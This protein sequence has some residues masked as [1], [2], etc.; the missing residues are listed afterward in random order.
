MQALVHQLSQRIN[1]YIRKL[2]YDIILHHI[3]QVIYF[4]LQLLNFASSRKRSREPNCTVQSIDS[5]KPIRCKYFLDKTRLP[6]GNWC[7][8]FLRC[9]Q[10]FFVFIEHW[11]H[12]WH[13]CWWC[14]ASTFRYWSYRLVL[15]EEKLPTTRNRRLGL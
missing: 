10:S 7:K 13:L 2:I 4:V 8:S 5:D 3:Q 11:C 1:S 9:T 12:H 14:C 15:Q 6:N